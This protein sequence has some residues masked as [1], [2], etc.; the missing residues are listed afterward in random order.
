MRRSLWI[1]FLIAGWCSSNSLVLL[2]GEPA[3]DRIQPYTENPRY[4]QFEGKPVLLLGGLKDDSPFQM[5]DLEAAMDE[6]VS[7]G[8]N[9]IR[10][11][12]SDRQDHDYEAYPYQK[13]EDG[14]YD[15]DQWN[16]EYWAR[17]ENLLKITRERD[18]IVQ[19]EV[20]D[21]FDYSREHWDRHP[22]RPSNN[23]NY[24]VAESGLRNSYPQHAHRD[25]QPFF[26]S[27]P[28][29]P[30]YENKLDRI[31]RYQERFVAKLLS[32]SLEYGHV[33]YCMDNETSTPPAWGR[34]WINFI[35]NQAR[36]KEALVFCTDMFDDGFQP[37]RSKSYAQ[38]IA[39]P[40]TYPFLDISQVNSRFFN[41]DQWVRLKWYE[42]QIA[43]H[44]R[45]L[46][47]TKIY[48]DGGFSFGSGRP[49]DGI[50]RF[51]RDLFV[52][53][54]AMRHH[55]DIAGIGLQPLAKNCI[56]A[57]RKLES[58]IQMWNVDDHQEL[59]SD[60]ESDEAYLVADSGKAYAI[61]FTA[62]G[63]VS[64]DLSSA[65]YDFQLK[66]IH[67]STGEAEQGALL[68]GGRKIK[69]K[70]PATAPCVAVLVRANQ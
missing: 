23:V 27:I 58:E 38:A 52:G 37:A 22:Y 60:R 35:Q 44:P 14:K 48:G 21:R 68:N 54:A 32:Y 59:L 70:A 24:S 30:L 26:H 63:E 61:Y 4:W 3:A 43:A 15:L 11:T 34:Y 66:W 9:Y 8:G 40:E 49:P 31:R 51:W 41:E 18:I 2:S 39:D 12:M 29:M 10:N 6:L 67:I 19:I 62:G 47:N 20:W 55:R 36:E 46:N 5:P 69:I 28:G 1:Y 25:Q 64:L 7:V 65:P 13:R 16:E 57:A 50:E 33:L 17:F 56:R 45:P 42:E 53:C